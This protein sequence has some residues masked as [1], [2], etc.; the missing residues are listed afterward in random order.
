MYIFNIKFVKGCF[1]AL[2]LI[3]D[4][5]MSVDDLWWLFSYNGG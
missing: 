5:D 2:L 1:E 3:T 4:Y